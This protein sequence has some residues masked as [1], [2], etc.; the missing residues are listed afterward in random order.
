[1]GSIIRK[2]IRRLAKS[3]LVNN[4]MVLLIVILY[5]MICQD[6][7]ALFSHFVFLSSCKLIVYR[8]IYAWIITNVIS[9]IKHSIP[10]AFF[11]NISE[12]SGQAWHNTSYRCIRVVKS[13]KSQYVYLN[14]KLFEPP[15]GKTNNLQRRKQRRR[16]E[17]LISAFVFATRIVHVLFFLNA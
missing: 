12:F 15:H 6:S 17:K 8:Y 9:H 14:A 10:D 7:I 3:V 4:V 11:A 13:T 5:Q 16:S 2:N 1:M